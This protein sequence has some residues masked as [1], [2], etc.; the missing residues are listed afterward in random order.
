MKNCKRFITGV[1]II[2]AIILPNHDAQANVCNQNN[3]DTHYENIYCNIRIFDNETADKEIVEILATQFGMSGDQ[4]KEVLADNICESIVEYSDSERAKLPQSIQDACLPAGSSV[5][6]TLRNWD[7]FENIRN[8]Y[9]KEKKIQQK[10]ASL[11]FKFK[12]S[13]QY[14]DG[15][16]KTILPDAPFDLIVDLNLI[17]IVLFG[18]QATWM[19]EVYSFPAK[20]EEAADGEEGDTPLDELLPDE[21]DEETTDE[22]FEDTEDPGIAVTKSGEGGLP[23]D[24]V[25]PDDPDADLGDGPGSGYEN[26]LCGNGVI[27]ILV[28]EQCDD[29]NDQSGDGCNQYCQTEASGSSDQCMDP[30]AVTFKKPKDNAGTDDENDDGS[31]NE[32]P[33]GMFPK[34]GTGFEGEEAG[35]PQEAPQSPEYP[36]PFLGGTMKQF[37]A[38]NKPPCPTGFFNASATEGGASATAKGE[39]TL[40]INIAGEQYDIPQCLP[41]EFCADFKDAQDFLFGEGWIEDEA[42]A[43]IAP[44]IQALFCVNIK[45]ENRPQSTYTED[46]G[47]VDCHITAMVDAVEG[48]LETNVTPLKNTTSSFS[49]SSPYGVNFSFNLN[50]ATKSKLKYKY[51]GTAQNSVGKANQSKAASENK[52]APV[53]TSQEKSKTTWQ[54]LSDTAKQSEASLDKTLRDTYVSQLT[55]EVISD[56]EVGGRINPLLLQMKGSFERIESKFEQMV[57]ETS[58]DTKEQ[59]P[60]N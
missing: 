44:A 36:G 12:V 15:E 31:A 58:L 27:D 18:S 53:T 52:A 1:L 37:P 34:S 16:I 3:T 26:T 24:C 35:P 46:E 14:W 39:E 33:E 56:Q 59:C 48:A 11:A 41:T 47:C 51:T 25:L 45:K 19:D 50:T 57:F 8:A 49:T 60:K 28:A 13:E 43:E 40:G 54:S 17:E 23:P 2:A 20:K 21:E 38:S 42:V 6:E 5:G 7:V 32:C 29:G 9:N 10:S 4:I 55:N 30:E 22:G